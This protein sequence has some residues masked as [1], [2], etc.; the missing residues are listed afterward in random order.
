MANFNR[1]ILMGNLTREPD[2]RYTAA[3][4]AVCDLGMAVNDRRKDAGGEWIEET[5][6]VDVTLWGGMAENAGKYLAKGSPV[7]VEGR[8]KLDLWEQNGQR[9]SKLRVIAERVQFLGNKQDAPAG[10]ASPA[11]NRHRQDGQNEHSGGYSGSI[12]F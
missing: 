9:R 2:V 6:F 7:H 5:T 12:P 10:D 4:T 1:V 8:L 3:G 11:E